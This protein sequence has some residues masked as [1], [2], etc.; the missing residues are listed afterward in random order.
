MKHVI[1]S[2]YASLQLWVNLAGSEA[3]VCLSDV[4]SPQLYALA[5]WQQIRPILYSSGVSGVC[6]SEDVFLFFQKTAAI[7]LLSR[8]NP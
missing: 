4:F 2:T 6:V 3:D 8:T 1:L 5:A 7:S